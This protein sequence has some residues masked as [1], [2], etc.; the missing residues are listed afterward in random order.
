MNETVNN[1]LLS[2]DKV[3][4]EMYLRQRSYK[5]CGSFTKNKV[6]IQKNKIGNSRYIYQNKLDRIC[7]PH[8]IVYGDF[9]DLSKRAASV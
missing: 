8:N 5:A 7:F 2:E 9:K 6:R 3:M 1:F 4:P